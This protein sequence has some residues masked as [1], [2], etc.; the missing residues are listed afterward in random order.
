[1]KPLQISQDI[2]SLA[3]FKNQ[4]S[5]IF[6]QLREEQRPIVV[7]QN[8]Q[9]AGVLITPEEFDRLQEHERF[10]TSVHAGLAD[11]EA[12]RLIDDDELAAELE[13]ELGQ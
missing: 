4:A 7:T 8:G 5:R 1:M 12:G 2:V 9:P 3:H 10:M 13:A 11:S 6:R